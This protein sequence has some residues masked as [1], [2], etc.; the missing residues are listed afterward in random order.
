MELK[1]GDL[2]TFEAFHSAVC[3]TLLLSTAS[4][5]N[6]NAELAGGELLPLVDASDLCALR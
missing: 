4:Q 3:N 6:L 5:L 2:A 1:P